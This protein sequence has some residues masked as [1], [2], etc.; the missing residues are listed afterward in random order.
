MINWVLQKNLTKPAI[1]ARIKNAAKLSNANWEEIEVVPFSNKL[2]QLKNISK[3]NIPYGSTTLMLNAYKDEKFAKGLFYDPSK[4]QM[5][6]YAQEWNSY[7]LNSPGVLISFGE[8]Y[9]LNFDD[10]K[11][12][13]IRPNNDGKEFS[14]QVLSFTKLKEW[15]K[16]VCKLNTLELNKNTQVWIS[17]PKKIE[18]EWRIFI[19]DDEI[20]SISRY[21]LNGQLD[22]S[23][24]DIPVR[25]IEF[26]ENRIR[27]YRLD[28][29]YVMDVA[30]SENEFKI[31]ECNCFNGTGFYMNDIEKIVTSINKFLNK[32]TS[33]NKV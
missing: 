28:D 12:V 19:V 32:N 23:S 26:I 9:T 18:K 31:I 25:L 29:V 4:F 17:E 3:V 6:N 24:N 33:E 22:E 8:F 14:G 27:E 15:S 20:I 30:K 10:N 7:M 13:F 1:L 5:R 11:L 2:P 21:M 16:E